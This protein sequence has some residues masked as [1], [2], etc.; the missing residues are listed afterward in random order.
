[1]HHSQPQRLYF[2]TL[3]F[4]LVENLTVVYLPLVAFFFHGK[5]NIGRP[6]KAIEQQDTSSP[7]KDRIS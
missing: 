2:L 5:G 4:L 1:M 3:L 7:A 6:A